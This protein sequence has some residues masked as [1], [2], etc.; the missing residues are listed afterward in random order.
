MRTLEPKNMAK[1]TLLTDDVRATTFSLAELRALWHDLQTRPN[2]NP[3][4]KNALNHWHR[5]TSLLR[6]RIDEMEKVKASE[7]GKDEARD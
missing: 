1:P 4:G 2:A 6:D 3:Y 5:A 7:E